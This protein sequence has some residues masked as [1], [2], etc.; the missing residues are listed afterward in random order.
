MG[1]KVD[2][3][4]WVY[5]SIVVFVLLCIL[6]AILTRLVLAPGYPELYPATSD[7]QDA[8]ILRLYT[9]L[10]RAIF[11]VLFV[12]IFIRG[13]EGKSGIGEGVRFGLWIG[14]LIYIPTIF[15]NLV[16]TNLSVG[17]HLTRAAGSLIETVLFGIAANMIYAKKAIV[18]KQ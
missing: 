6:E 16:V 17:L 18:Q 5:A 8:T 10:G 11:S 13:Y 3:K 15:Y 12:Y 14:V 7:V 4:K 9:Y 2:V 1:S